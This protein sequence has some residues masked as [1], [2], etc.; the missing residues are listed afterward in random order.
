MPSLSMLKEQS[1]QQVVVGPQDSHMEK[2]KVGTLLHTITKTKPKCV[3]DVNVRAS[4]IEHS[5]DNRDKSL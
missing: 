3:K 5:K 4:S 2:S 1:F